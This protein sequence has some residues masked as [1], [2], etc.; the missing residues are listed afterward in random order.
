MFDLFWCAQTT[1]LDVDVFAPYLPM[2]VTELVRLRSEADTMEIKRR[3][4]TT[5]NVVIER[6]EGRVSPN[7]RHIPLFH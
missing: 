4:C 5:L 7:H 1:S 3:V 2:T 6:S